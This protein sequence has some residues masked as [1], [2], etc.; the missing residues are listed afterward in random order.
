MSTKRPSAY[1][2]FRIAECGLKEKKAESRRQQRQDLLSLRPT[3]YCLLPSVLPSPHSTSSFEHIFQNEPDVRGAFSQPPHEIRIPVLAIRHIDAHV[4]AIIRQLRLKVAAHAI[5]HLK[6]ESFF[7]YSLTL[8]VI[9][10]GIYHLRV[11]RCNAVIDARREQSFHHAN[12]VFINIFFIWKSNFGR[13]V[14]SAF[15]DAYARWD[16]QYI[17]NVIECPTQVGLQDNAYIVQAK[18]SAQTLEYI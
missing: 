8:G 2:G 14:V 1:F 3:A 7:T 4:V 5:E 18:L 16:F 13:L 11:M 9:N 15:A 6:L 12:V 10:R 17:L